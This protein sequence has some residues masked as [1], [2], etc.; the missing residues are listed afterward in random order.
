MTITT[1]HHLIRDLVAQA[2]FLQPLDLFAHIAEYDFSDDTH[3][4]NFANDA[5]TRRMVA[6]VLGTL[7]REGRIAEGDVIPIMSKLLSVRGFYGT[8]CQMM[9]YAWMQ[10][11]NIDFNAE[12]WIPGAGLIN[13]NDVALDGRF[14]ATDALFEVKAMGIQNKL[15]SDFIEK[16]KPHFPGHVILVDG[17]DDSAFSDIADKAL[18]KTREIAKALQHQNHVEIEG[19]GWI[20]RKEPHGKTLYT[21]TTEF[22]PYLFA[23]QNQLF[24]YRHCSQFVLGHPFILVCVYS[25]DFGSSVL[26]TNFEGMRDVALRALA[27]RSFI[28]F[29][30]NPEKAHHYDPKAGPGHTLGD[31]CAALSGILFLKAKS[32]DA[33]LYLNP[34]ARHPVTP[35]GLGRIFHATRMRIDDFS[36][37]NY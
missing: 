4:Y 29:S 37:D 2:P 19:L 33:N 18:S 17:R 24:A 10:E 23:E 26:T 22:D 9:V 15:K 3:L 5:P 12:V 31:A 32:F 25:G 28:A 11:N 7:A 21:S 14:N 34:N 35:D 13:E 8:Y 1:T 16:L 36:H 6:R 20:V 27:R 30:G